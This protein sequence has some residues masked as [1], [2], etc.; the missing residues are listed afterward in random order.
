MVEF[1]G[2]LRTHVE[3]EADEVAADPRDKGKMAQ[4]KELLADHFGRYERMGHTD[5]R[6]IVFATYKVT[7]ANIV[8]Y[9][10]RGT[11]G[12]RPSIFTGQGSGKGAGK[13]KDKDA[14]AQA[15]DPDA[16]ESAGQLLMNEPMTQER[17]KAIV[18]DFKHGVYV[19]SPCCCCCCCYAHGLL[20]LPLLLLPLPTTHPSPPPG[21]PPGAPCPPP[22]PLGSPWGALGGAW[23]ASRPPWGAER[24]PEGPAT[25]TRWPRRTPA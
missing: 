10:K 23:G 5:T 21:A 11:T 19:A 14:A 8:A 24:A 6:A 25:D 9:L 12:L 7:V 16:L 17:Q 15:G 3:V 2:T 1:I 4:C 18:R 13:K 20:L 22:G